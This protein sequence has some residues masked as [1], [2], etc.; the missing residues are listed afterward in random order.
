[1][2][3]EAPARPPRPPGVEPEGAAQDAEGG[4]GP[5]SRPPRLERAA[6]VG[7][8]LAAGLL[9]AASVPPFGWW[10]LAWVGA[11]LLVARAPREGRG[12][13]F[14]LGLAAGFGLFVPGWWWMHEFSFPGFLLAVPTESLFVG[15]AMLLV[16]SAGRRSRSRRQGG[17]PGGGRHAGGWH[18]GG[19]AVPAALVLGEA[20]R[21]RF[22][23]GGVP[24]GGVDLGQV[25][26][27]LA[28][29]ARLGGHLLLV[30]L[31]GLGGVGL[32]AV[33]RAVAAGEAETG[34]VRVR[35]LASAGLAFALVAGLAVAGVTVPRGRVVGR[36][37]AAAVQGGGPRG[38]RAI[39]RDPQPVYA[40]HLAASARIAA[41]VDVV[42]WPEDVIHV[43]A[44]AGS[45]EDADLT[46]LADRLG[47]PVI[48]GVIED[49]GPDRFHNS[50]YLWL[51]GIGRAG[52]YEKVHRVPFG[53]YVPGRSLVAHVA[54]LHLIPS[55]A[56]AG[57]GPGL[58]RAPVPVGSVGVAISYE[59]FYAERARAAI[60]AGG[61][62]L[63]VPTNAA[64]F[65]T[66]QVPAQ[67]LAAARLRALEVGRDV[68]Q[69]APTGYT[70][71]IGA[72]GRVHAH[73][74]LGAAAVLS[75]TVDVRRGSTLYLRT[76]DAPAVV[77]ALLCLMLL[78]KKT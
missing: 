61:G 37:R 33:W 6:T 26:G 9:M 17:W 46:A 29:A 76:G 74:D 50:A 55:E 30:G 14:L 52:R 70:A 13:R 20:A 23:F 39:D 44:I 41:G 68:V 66:G 63:L 60:R 7:I 25:G 10:P 62:V 2:G 67:E 72:S 27:P 11:A 3:T 15:L 78:W 64:S 38:L 54:D 31:A 19:W 40:A 1:M 18:A 32:V 34:R 75:R 12:R 73:T 59:V 28:P 49:A 4:P 65:R 8:G 45:P 35:P 21:D 53:E 24:L 48:A 69:A 22:P 56:V 51:P 43:D 36:L 5:P 77:V 16:P 57:H 47:A 58:L 42:L 71:I